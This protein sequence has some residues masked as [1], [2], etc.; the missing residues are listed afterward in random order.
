MDNASINILGAIEVGAAIA[1][2]AKRK[3][4]GS[5]PRQASGVVIA[6]LKE[7]R[8]IA[9]KLDQATAPA[10]PTEEARAMRRMLLDSVKEQIALLIA[11]LGASLESGGKPQR[12]P[13]VRVTNRASEGSE[14]LVLG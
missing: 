5:A 9:K 10:P 11:E 2:S 7:L 4:K 3:G 14:P 1:E 6:M 13:L 8:L 12:K